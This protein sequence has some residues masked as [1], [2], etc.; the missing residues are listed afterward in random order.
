[1]NAYPY[2]VIH[3]LELPALF[4]HRAKNDLE[5]VDQVIEDDNSPL[6]A[7][8]FGEATGVN[9]AHLLEDSR[10]ATLSGTYKPARLATLR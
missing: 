4:L 8:G 3:V 1:M 9:D 10:L 7:L 6:L 5:S 2:N